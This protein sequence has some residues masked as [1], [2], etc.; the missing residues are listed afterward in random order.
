MTNPRAQAP[1]LA[2]SMTNHKHS[3]N[4]LL[5]TVENLEQRH[6]HLL[7]AWLTIEHSDYHLLIAYPRAQWW[8]LTAWPNKLSQTLAERSDTR[9][10]QSIAGSITDSVSTV[11]ITHKVAVECLVLSRQ[12]PDKSISKLRSQT[13]VMIKALCD[14]LRQIVRQKLEVAKAVSC[15]KYWPSPLLLNNPVHST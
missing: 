3:D 11:F 1:S 15:C 12:N 4:H 14:A 9:Q 2:D 5:I 6:H 8:S 7:I 10:A 13:A